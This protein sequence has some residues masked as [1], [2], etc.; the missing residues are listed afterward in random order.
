MWEEYSQH[1]SQA[2]LLQQINLLYKHML[3]C[4]RYYHVQIYASSIAKI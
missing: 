3:L 1:D 2:S 4:Y